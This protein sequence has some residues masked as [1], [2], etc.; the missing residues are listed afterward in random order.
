MF[1]NVIETYSEILERFRQATGQRNAILAGGCLRDTFYGVE[2]KD[3]DFVVQRYWPGAEMLR[4]MW[5]DK[6][7]RYI[8]R[9]FEYDVPNNPAG[10]LDVLESEEKDIN[11]IIVQDIPRYTNQFPD[12]I[13]QMVFDGEQVI[14]SDKW[15]AGE[16]AGTVNYK[17]D[18]KT[19]R[20]MKLKTKYPNWEFI[21]E[22]W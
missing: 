5:P 17:W 15:R 2:V 1:N 6:R 18:I 11:I 3:L 14:V 10:L 13:S 20:L 4:Q 8:A 9:D 21:P 12:S 16:L 22:A 19:P 7:F